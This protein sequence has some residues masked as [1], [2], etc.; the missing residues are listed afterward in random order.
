MI[1]SD[2]IAEWRAN[3]PWA[4]LFM[5]EQDLIIT[6]ALV[7]MFSN[8]VLAEGIAFRGGTALYK[9]Y[10]LPPTRYSEDI[11][12]VQVRSGPA[13]V[14]LDAFHETLDPW[15]GM[16]RWSQN[17][18]RIALIYRFQSEDTPPLKLRL[19]I[20]INTREHFSAF[21][22]KRIPFSV[23]SRWFNGAADILTYEF[24]ELLATKM[25]AL[26]QRKKGRDLFDLDAGLSKETANAN[27]IVEAFNTYLEQEGGRVTRAMFERNLSQKLQ[28]P[29]FS[30]DIGPLLSD[31]AKW[32][33]ANAAQAVSERLIALLPG[34][35][36]KGTG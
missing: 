31:S 10:I 15:L 4:E 7:E 23:E 13:G 19:K 32:D 21:E 22:F 16:P 18:G 12:L 1:P 36:W 29:R 26:Y 9:L 25:R 30:S 3:A 14:L 5:V 17:E 33:M 11:D 6:R 8:S 28:D 35:P 27:R 24:D 20:E 2:H 34:E